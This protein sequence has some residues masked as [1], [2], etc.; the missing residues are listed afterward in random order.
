MHQNQNQN[1]NQGPNQAPKQN[2]PADG[3]P[4]NALPPLNAFIPNAPSGPAEPQRLHLN[5]PHFKPEYI[6]KPNKDT[7]VHLL[8]TNNW[9]G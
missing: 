4:Q 9:M 6:G 2:P 8:K 1:Q 5:W 7:E 3:D